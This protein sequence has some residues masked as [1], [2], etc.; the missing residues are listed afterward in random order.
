[1]IIFHP[2]AA[3]ALGTGSCLNQSIWLETLTIVLLSGWTP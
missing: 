3:A 1:M 2:D